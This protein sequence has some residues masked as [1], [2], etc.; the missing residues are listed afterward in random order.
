MWRGEE[1]KKG[2]GGFEYI[3][4]DEHSTVFTFCDCLGAKEWSSGSVGG[5]V[6]RSVCVAGGVCGAV[7]LLLRLRFERA[8]VAT[9]P[10]WLAEFERV[11]LPIR[12]TLP[13]CLQAVERGREVNTPGAIRMP[14][15]AFPS[16][17]PCPPV[18]GA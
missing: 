18:I 2:G 4:K 12:F 8:E 11:R 10:L 16:G 14:V 5:S 13:L 7:A 1:Q 3:M 6:C 9:K 17:G 15:P